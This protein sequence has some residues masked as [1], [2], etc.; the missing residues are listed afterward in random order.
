MGNNMNNLLPVFM[1]LEE[2][3]C[4]VIGGG[5]I[6]LQKIHQLLDS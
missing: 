5:K 2:A 6:A 3:T 4:L 1:K